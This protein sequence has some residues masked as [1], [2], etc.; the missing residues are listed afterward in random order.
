MRSEIKIIHFFK[1]LVEM[2]KTILLVRDKSIQL[3]IKNHFVFH[4]CLMFVKFIYNNL[5]RIFYLISAFR[6][7]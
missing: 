6:V 4:L 3:T 2:M 5:Q 1:H 7:K